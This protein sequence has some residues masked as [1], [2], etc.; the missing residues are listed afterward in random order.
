MAAVF[1]G[2]SHA[3]LASIV[4]AFEATRQ[5][6]GLLPLL[7]GCSA[8][9]MISILLMR[10][11]IMTEKLARRGAPV[12]TEYSVDFLSQ[13]LVRDGMTAQV[14]TLQ[15]D[16]PLGSVRERLSSDLSET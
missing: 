13:V 8:A 6:L 7:A 14:T 1:A 15:A 16:E 2:A 3:L 11:S 4:F 9:Y 10:T 5:A 12:R